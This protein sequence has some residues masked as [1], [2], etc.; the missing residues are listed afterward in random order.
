M[1]VKNL[2]QELDLK[3]I[4][5]GDL[6]REVSGGYICDLLS[7]VMARAKAGDFWFT[8]Q[9]HQNIIAVSLLTDVAGIIVVE[10]FEIEQDTIKKAEAKAINLFQSS[11]SAYELA[12]KLYQLGIK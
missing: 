2:V 11:L 1:K 7:N 10:D 9:G 6:E 4:V 5:E 3:I 12:G 8:V